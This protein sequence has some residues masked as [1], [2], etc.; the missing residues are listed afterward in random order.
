MYRSFLRLSS[1]FWLHCVGTARTARG[2][3]A[4]DVHPR[5]MR[6]AVALNMAEK[7]PAVAFVEGNV[8]RDEIQRV[9]TALFH[10][11]KLLREAS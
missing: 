2:S 10:I 1:L 9:D 4:V 7:F 6:F 8:I 11:V 3:G 5:R